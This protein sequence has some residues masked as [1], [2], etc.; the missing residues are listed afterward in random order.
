MLTSVQILIALQTRI[1]ELLLA[2]T[3]AFNNSIDPKLPEIERRAW[4]NQS[5]ALTLA[6]QELRAIAILIEK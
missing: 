2:D 5:A 6:R 3:T 4:R 1:E